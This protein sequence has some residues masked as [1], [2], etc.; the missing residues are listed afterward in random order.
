MQIYS[1]QLKLKT[2]SF[3]FYSSTLIQNTYVTAICSMISLKTLEEFKFCDKIRRQRNSAP[4]SRWLRLLS[5]FYSTYYIVPF[6]SEHCIECCQQKTYGFLG[7][8]SLSL[9][10]VSRALISSLTDI[11]KMRLRL[12]YFFTI[13]RPPLFF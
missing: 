13:S 6:W 2:L 12:A 11:G 7:N 10:S 1:C 8:Q 5:Q 4:K 3:I 9:R